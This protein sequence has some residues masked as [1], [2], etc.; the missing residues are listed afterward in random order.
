MYSETGMIALYVIVLGILISVCNEKNRKC[1]LANKHIYQIEKKLAKL[2]NGY[3]M[4]FALCMV[5]GILVRCWRFCDL[6]GGMN[7]DE[8]MAG[9]EAFSLLRT[10]RDHHGISWPTYFKAWTTSQMSTLYSYYMIPFVWLFGDLNKLV[11]RLPA[12]LLNLSM[13]PLIW[14]LAR[15]VIGKNYALLV[16]FVLATN[17]WHI[18]QGR[19]ALEANMM[20]HVFLV[21]VYFLF[22][23]RNSKP[24]LYLSMVFFGLAPYA[25]GVASF[26]VPVFLAAA[27][28]YYLGRRKASALDLIVC[29]SIF[30]SIAWP[31]YYT[32]AINAFGLETLNI[33]V[34]TLP[35][36]AES[37]R[38]EGL[39]FSQTNPFEFFT[40]S[41]SEHLDTYVF[42]RSVEQ[43]N[44]IPWIGPMY[45]FMTPVFVYAIYRLWRDRRE[46][47]RCLSDSGFRDGGFLLLAWLGAAVFNGIMVGGV[48]NRNNVLYY[49]L[50]LLAA[51]GMYW[52]GRKMKTALAVLLAIVAVGFSGFCAVYFFDNEY[53]NRVEE[54][55]YGGLHEALAEAWEIDCD[56]YYITDIPDCHVMF[57]HKL[58]WEQVSDHVQVA[59]SGGRRTDAYYSQKYIY[60]DFDE[61]EPDSR[62]KAVY[63]VRI[64][65]VDCFSDGEYTA[66]RYGGYAVVYPRGSVVR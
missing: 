51:Y 8:T 44:S 17:P 54:A 52:V 43:Y 36:F 57:A 2:Q 31:Y 56:R 45:G 15:R 37:V 59:D 65:E 25:Y 50:I 41:F 40:N 19:W 34:F 61:F 1:L 39:V 14:D 33:G 11:L 63:I 30:A 5:F 62:E 58:D 64:D 60:V 16:L 3:W 27:A 35:R 22:V 42:N 38:A 20:P 21:A 55:F 9:L 49:P 66:E 32:L 13:L 6:P 18:M 47:A 4:A 46:Q 28:I 29:I 48:I 10:G 12:L 23:G 26:S 24:A 53:Q 7:Q